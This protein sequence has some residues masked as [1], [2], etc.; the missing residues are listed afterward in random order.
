MKHRSNFKKVEKEE[1]NKEMKKNENVDCKI[2]YQDTNA[3]RLD[4]KNECVGREGF[5]PSGQPSRRGRGSLRMRGGVNR[6][7]D[8]YGPPPAKSPFGRPEDKKVRDK[9][10]ENVSDDKINPEEEIK[11]KQKLQTSS[12][13]Q[14]NAAQKTNQGGIKSSHNNVPPRMQKKPD[15]DSRYEVLYKSSQKKLVLLC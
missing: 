13:P 5:A 1:R 11:G 8:G 6:R 7:L 15:V 14:N 9:S 10:S 12:T 2:N 4:R 3:A